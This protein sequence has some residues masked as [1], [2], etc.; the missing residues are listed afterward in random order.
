MLL[1]GTDFCVLLCVSAWTDGDQTNM[2]T[3]ARLCTYHAHHGGYT[4]PRGS[5][6]HTLTLSSSLLELGQR[7]RRGYDAD[8]S[9][10]DHRSRIYRIGS[11]RVTH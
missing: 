9:R 10:I 11:A 3:Q 4:I 1:T 6:Q 5:E 7:C 8:T 2:I